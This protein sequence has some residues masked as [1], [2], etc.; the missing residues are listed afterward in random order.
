[1]VI[2]SLLLSKLRNVQNYSNEVQFVRC[3]K[4]EFSVVVFR[5]G[6]SLV[7]FYVFLILMAFQGLLSTVGFIFMRIISKFIRILVFWIC[8]GVMVGSTWIFSNYMSGQW[9]MG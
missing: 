8:K 3:G 2:Q 1:M 9:L 4:K 6:Q 7:C 5:R